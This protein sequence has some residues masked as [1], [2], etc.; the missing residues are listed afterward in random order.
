MEGRW[1][2]LLSSSSSSSAACSSCSF[3]ASHYYCNYSSPKPYL[4]PFQSHT[5]TNFPRRLRFVLKTFLFSS[6]APPRFSLQ[7]LVRPTSALVF[8]DQ[9]LRKSNAPSRSQPTSSTPS[10]SSSSPPKEMLPKIDKSGRFC[11]PRAAREL[12]LLVH[13]LFF[14]HSRLFF[15]LFFPQFF[16]FHVSSFPFF[17]P[18][19]LNIHVFSFLFFFFFFSPLK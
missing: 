6:S 17:S 13:R 16:N 7:F 12:A 3:T 4:L 8:D 19:F 18:K 10:F 5:Y 9:L 15:S 14:K 1:S 11:S 2:L